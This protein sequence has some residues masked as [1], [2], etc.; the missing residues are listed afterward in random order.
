MGLLLAC[1][2]GLTG[3]V[4]AQ[5]S[6]SSNY[7]VNEVFFGTGSTN[8]CLE[9]AQNAGKTYCA[10]QS[11]GELTVGNTSSNNYQA[12]AGFNTD[13]TPWISIGI[14]GS[15][16]VDLGVLAADE[17]KAATAQ[18]RVSAYLSH[19]YSVQVVGPPPTYGGHTLAAMNNAASSI[20]TEQFGINLRANS[21]GTATPSTFGA[22]PA[23]DPDYPAQPFGF[24]AA[25]DDTGSGQVYD[26]A[27]QFRYASGDVIAKSAKS[28]SYTLYT[29][30]YIANITGLTPAGEYKTAQS[31]VATATF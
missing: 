9:W 23:Q 3:G 16:N 24:G 28:S 20:G 18:F 10:K 6:S 25:N 7:S 30:S 29:I 13:R 17:T 4:F 27:N 5:Q 2:F 8:T 1:L 12:Q 21:V 15:P 19:G 14:V 31:L 26:V 22:D 11:A